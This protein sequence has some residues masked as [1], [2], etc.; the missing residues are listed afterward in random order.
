[1]LK[2][3]L[4]LLAMLALIA[5]IAVAMTVLNH[6]SGEAV[7]HDVS[8]S[9]RDTIY[10]GT[11]TKKELTEL[12]KKK[13][14]YP[15]GKKLSGISTKALE[16][17]LDKHSLIDHA[18]CFKTP[19]G[20][21]HIEVT[22]RIPLLHVMASNGE[23]YFID[24]KGQMMPA[25]AKC[26]ARKTIVTGSVEKSFATSDLYNFGVFLQNNPFWNA[27]IEQINVLP[28]NNVE[29][30]PRVGEHIIYL[31][32]L[33]R[34]E[35]KL[36]ALKSFYVKGLNQVGWNKYSRISLEFSNQIICTKADEKK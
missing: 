3:I 11:V 29:L 35:E 34:Y 2:R 15:V 28:G 17:E 19:A 22:Q 33:N 8:M 4:L 25:T 26:V 21:I 20:G 9:F 6:N 5:Y 12:L 1:M 14:L 23:N 24:N 30:V 16:A 27:Q 31:G 7:C 36:D 10:G 18:E 32:K 13:K